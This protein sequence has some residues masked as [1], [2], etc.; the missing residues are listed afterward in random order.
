[1]GRDLKGVSLPSYTTET[2]FSSTH[3]SLLPVL[4]V[5]VVIVGDKDETDQASLFV[6]LTEEIEGEE[7]ESSFDHRSSRSSRSG[8]RQGLKDR[9]ATVSNGERGGDWGM[10]G[11]TAG[12]NSWVDDD[13][14][15]DDDM[16]GMGIGDAGASVTSAVNEVRSAN[17]FFFFR[18]PIRAPVS[19]I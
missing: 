2:N 1:M 17:F 6:G 9:A 13:D 8:E 14:D 18:N 10:V 15:D 11:M 3:V 5:V 12:W 19:S 7:C 4:V 16:G